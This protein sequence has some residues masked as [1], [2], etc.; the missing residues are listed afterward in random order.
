[1]QDQ[2][3]FA[4]ILETEKVWVQVNK[5]IH[6]KGAC[7]FSCGGG[8]ELGVKRGIREKALKRSTETRIT[9]TVNL[10]LPETINLLV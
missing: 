9:A 5:K 1:M 10:G 2:S 8:R 3:T 6:S 7:G 4:A